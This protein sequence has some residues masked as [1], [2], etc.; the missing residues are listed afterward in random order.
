MEWIERL[1]EAIH[2]MEEHM[3][4]TIDMN[5]VG[6]IAGCSTYHFQRMF[7]Y[8]S[9]FSLSVYIRN[10]KF[11]IAATEQKNEANKAKD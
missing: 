8:M 4:D 1:N 6:K 10:S 2:Y 5:E 11:S 9:V 3:C 7:A